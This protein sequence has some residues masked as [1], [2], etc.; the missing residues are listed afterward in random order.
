MGNSADK[1]HKMIPNPVHSLPTYT[2]Q[3]SVVNTIVEINTHTINKYEIIPETGHLK[4]DRVG[5][6]SLAYP[7]VYGAIPQTWDLDE[8]ALDVVIANVIEPLVPNSIAEVRIIGIMK[9]EDDGEGDDKVIGVLADDKRSNHIDSYEY[10][11]E[12]WLKE[13]TYYF[14]H[15]KD[16]K[17]TDICKVTGFE[18]IDYANKII[19]EA[20]ERYNQEVKP[21]LI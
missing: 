13:I 17:K 2:E 21:H 9:F 19:K 1:Y 5:Y 20:M 16:L 7:V 4:L 3:D 8:D 10:F 14:E 6:S 11:G 12:H 18:G 15:Y